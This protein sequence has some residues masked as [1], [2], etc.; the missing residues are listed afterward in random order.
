MSPTFGVAFGGGGARGLAHIHIIEALDELGIK[1]AAIAGSSI[2]AIM[3]AGMASGMKGAEIHDY[4]RSILGSR[5]EVAA[6]MWRS[7][8]GTIAEAMQGGIRV[9]QFNIERILKAFLPQDIPAAFEELKIPL[10]VTATDYFGHK[11]AVFAEGELHSALAASAAIPAVFRPV[12]RNDCLLID[13]GIYNPVPFDLLEKDADIVIAIDV[14]GAPS[15][16]ERKH[17]TTVDLM[18][19]ASQLMMQS[20]IAN[21]LQQ[22]SPDILIRPKVSKYRVLDFLKIE[23]LMAETAEIKD[24]L[25][26]AVEKA[27]EAYGGRQGNKKVV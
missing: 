27:V 25:K 10:K 26:R 11:L 23:A 9:G 17:P 21:K 4:A 18:Y 16:A 22:S 19:G 20:I 24:E 14:V 15:D 6:R 8:P 12:V 1:P 3:G 7:R 2:G 13:G 5:A